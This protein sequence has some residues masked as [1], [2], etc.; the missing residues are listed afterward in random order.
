MV[1]ELKNCCANCLNFVNKKCQKEYAPDVVF[2]CYNFKPIK[3]ERGELSAEN[4]RALW[5]DWIT[6]NRS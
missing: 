6:E 1:K 3:V 4:I 5:R 2:E